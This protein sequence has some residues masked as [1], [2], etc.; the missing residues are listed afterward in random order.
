[1][2]V[3]IKLP[4]WFTAAGYKLPA[5]FPMSLRK[6]GYAKS[7]NNQMKWVCGCISP[8][9]AVARLHARIKAGD[10]DRKQ[11]LMLKATEPDGQ[12]V[13]TVKELSNL[14]MGWLRQRIETKKPRPFKARTYEDYRLAIQLFNDTRW[15]DG[16]GNSD[17]L[18]NQPAVKLGP[19]QFAAYASRIPGQSPYTRDR[20]IAPIVAMYK[21][22]VENDHLP[23]PVK[24]GSDMKKT[25]KDERRDSRANIQKEF[26]RDEV[27]KLVTAA[28]DKPLW[29]SMVLLGL[30][31]GFH[32]ADLGALPREV[33]ELD[34]RVIEFRRGKKGRAYRKA[35]LW[36]E[37]IDALRSYRRPEPGDKRFLKRPDVYGPCFE[38]HGDLFFLTTF[39]MPLSRACEERSERGTLLSAN[40]VDAA[41]GEFYKLMKAAD[42]HSVGRG[43]S[44][45]RTTFRTLAEGMPVKD[46]DAINL[47]MGH[48]DRHISAEYVERFPEAKLYAVVD[49]VWRELFEGWTSELPTQVPAAAADPAA[50]P[51]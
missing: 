27:R 24:M 48:T 40:R 13:V 44:G 32:N 19:A 31:A 22:G 49:H 8:R 43:L 34:R 39:A 2:A 41:A 35:P 36:R 25:S 37:T 28:A 45:L 12:Q 5:K 26:S 50:V 42:V 20:Y 9:E 29:I 18:A 23:H 30:N 17:R 7:F 1:M 10:F 51:S 6:D 33:V 16:G 47:I 21:W 4:D 14:Y 3:T 11:P 38:K 15:T 46:D